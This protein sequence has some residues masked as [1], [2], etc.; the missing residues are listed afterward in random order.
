M[1]KDKYENSSRIQKLKMLENSNLK[2]S[3]SCVSILRNKS[4]T[5]DDHLKATLF[6]E[7]NQ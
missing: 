5:P 2:E 6:Y 3:K 1:L 7:K 4:F